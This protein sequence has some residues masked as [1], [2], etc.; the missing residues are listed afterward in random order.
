[1]ST[2]VKKLSKF[3]QSSKEILFTTT[4]EKVITP[5]KKGTPVNVKASI[6]HNDLL[7]FFGEKK[8]TNIFQTEIKLNG[9]I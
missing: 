6:N 5:H 2:G 9:C 8:D 7:R 3:I 4:D 1:M